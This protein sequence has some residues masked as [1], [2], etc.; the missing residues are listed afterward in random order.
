MR[1]SATLGYRNHVSSLTVWLLVGVGAACWDGYFQW[2]AV[3]S[4]CDAA[5]EGEQ[6]VGDSWAFTSNNSR[7]INLI[8]IIGYYGIPVFFWVLQKCRKSHF[9][10]R[11]RHSSVFTVEL[12]CVSTSIEWRLTFVGL[13]CIYAFMTSLSATLFQESLWWS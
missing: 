1:I 8:P 7:P 9:K 11:Y 2:S 6:Q 5:S 12:W 13:S 10:P 3:V 4:E